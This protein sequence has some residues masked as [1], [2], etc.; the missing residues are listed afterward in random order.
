LGS[1]V[2]E[3]VPA[4]AIVADEVGNFLEGLVRDRVLKWHF[5]LWGIEGIVDNAMV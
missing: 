3:F 4:V 1:V 2:T 5:W